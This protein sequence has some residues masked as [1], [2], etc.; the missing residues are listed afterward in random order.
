M[1]KLFLGTLIS[2]MMAS[3]VAY[4]ADP[5]TCIG[6]MYGVN[7]RGA[8]KL[9]KLNQ[10]F[11]AV[12]SSVVS[13][14][15]SAALAYSSNEHRL[16]YVTLAK[17]N[18]VSSL[19]YVDLDDG[20]HHVVG[21]TQH[22]FRLTFSP[23]GQTLYGSKGKDLYTFNT[24]TAEAT[25]L[26]K[27][28]GFPLNVDTQ[29]GDIAFVDN[30]LYLVS[31]KRIFTVNLT[32]LTVTT[33]AEH[34]IH[35]VNGAEFG[36][37]GK[38]I[39]SRTL[40][41]KS[42]IFEYDLASKSKR[43]LSTVNARLNDLA[44]DTSVCE[45]APV[46]SVS[47]ITANKSQV[48]EGDVVDYTVSLTGQTTAEQGLNIAFAAN[49]TKS[50]VD[51][52]SLLSV[53]Y[54]GGITWTEV[55]DA[56]RSATLLLPIGTSAVTFRALTLVDGRDPDEQM[57]LQAWM[58]L[59]QSDLD[60]AVTT[61]IDRSKDPSLDGQ[62][63]KLMTTAVPTMVEGQYTESKIELIRTTDRH[64]PMHIQFINQTAKKAEDIN[65]LVTVSYSAADA[66]YRYD[67][68]LLDFKVLNLPVGVSEL[69]VRY[70]A[71]NDDVVD[72]K[73][74]FSFAS[75]IVGRGV[76][77]FK[78]EVTI[79][80][81]SSQ[82]IV[83]PEETGFTLNAISDNVNEGETAKF[84]LV[85]DKELNS[86]ATVTVSAV[87][88]SANTEDYTLATYDLIIPK[89]E[90]SAFIE[91]PT[92]DD[93]EFE[94]Q[95]SFTLNVAGK[96]NTSGSQSAAVY[97]TDNDPEPAVGFTVEAIADNVTEGEPAKFTIHLEKAL[98][99][100]ATVNVSVV[101]GSATASD[102]N[103]A[104]TEYKIM[105]GET[106]VAVTIPTIDDNQYEGTESFTMKVNAGVN[107]KGETSNNANILDNEITPIDQLRQAAA[108]SQVN[109]EGSHGCCNGQYIRGIKGHFA[110]MPYGTVIRFYIGGS[111]HATHTY[112]GQYTIYAV[113]SQHAPWINNGTAA[114]A[115]ATYNGT[116]VNVRGAHRV[117][118]GSNPWVDCS[119][120]CY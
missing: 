16:Y 85:L 44:L 5:L 34:G 104:N 107:T 81:P 94:P 75:W 10:S 93:N 80:D 101:A 68:D 60:S 73:E 64:T 71:L 8:A 99:S 53:S 106:S 31:K 18:G 38:L 11:T 84:E 72:C 103:F 12:D 9:F 7:N 67:L 33:F 83:D 116:T 20:S 45:V 61:L 23:D 109:W 26:G 13:L 112:N 114:W 2:G 15:N 82:C 21:N 39:L 19:V 52:S 22:V 55:V 88:G 59:D 95:E 29:M 65:Q 98:S 102:Y 28:S 78:D 3:S 25:H 108:T 47:S 43:E 46:I 79:T 111:L 117:Q 48:D 50:K 97:I 86:D 62:Y 58:N 30:Q 51:F 100:D 17:P 24:D 118:Y 119:N 63:I 36:G 105:A 35:H 115:T 41:D 37:A 42:K 40:Q 1:N 77:Y 76:D 6:D 89:G 110:G 57:E 120:G 70:Q 90:V 54:D 69:T 113:D 96:T 66:D 91:I 87:P 32:D 14:G 27:L 56:N 74:N 4:A 49:G 92:L